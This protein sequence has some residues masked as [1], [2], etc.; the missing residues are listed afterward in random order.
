MVVK[1]L[2]SKCMLWK[3]KIPIF[4]FYWKIV[5]LLSVLVSSYDNFFIA[6]FYLW[7]YIYT[8]VC[9]LL[10]WRIIW[11]NSPLIQLWAPL[12]LAVRDILQARKRSKVHHQLSYSCHMCNFH[13][14]FCLFYFVLL[15]ASVPYYCVFCFQRLLLHLRWKLI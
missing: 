15:A 4:L 5:V 8:Y 12:H 3:G 13:H 14:Q 11:G 7:V 10:V 6:E 1:K 9:F 2:E